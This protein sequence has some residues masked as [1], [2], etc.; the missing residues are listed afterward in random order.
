MDKHETKRLSK[1]LSL[2]LRHQPEKVGITLDE[3]GWVEIATLLDGI[4][5]SGRNVTRRQL[6]QVVKSNDKQRFSISDDNQ[7]IRAK[8]GHSVA[9]ELGYQPTKP[10][11]TLC[12]GTP[13]KYMELIRQGGL[14]K[15]QRHHVHMHADDKL[16]KEVGGRR[17]QPVLLI[18]RS[19]EMH[20]EGYEFF[21]TNNEVWLTDHVPPQYIDFPSGKIE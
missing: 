19:L 14:K 20:E 6:E 5:K 10:P 13:I 3:N 4:C 11:K 9:V 12:H 2:I 18:I 17:G 7:R 1:F 21:V 16:A 8:Q 15:M